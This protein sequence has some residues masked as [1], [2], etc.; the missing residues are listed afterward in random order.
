MVGPKGEKMAKG[1]ERERKGVQKRDSVDDG[2]NE[3]ASVT[4]FAPI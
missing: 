4:K 1:K 3:C 2:N